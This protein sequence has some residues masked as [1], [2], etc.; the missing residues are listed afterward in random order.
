MT[1]RDT[2][3]RGD[4]WT[5]G[6]RGW[7]GGGYRENKKRELLLWFYLLFVIMLHT[8]QWGFRPRSRA[9]E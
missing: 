8:G 5:D 6:E 9:Y 1:D 7:G 2:D 4:T 3:N